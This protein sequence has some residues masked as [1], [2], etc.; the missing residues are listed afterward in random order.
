M[1]S[2]VLTQALVIGC[3]YATLALG[4]L[5]DVAAAGEKQNV[6]VLA[7]RDSQQPAYELFMG[8]FRAGL[9]ARAANRLELFTEFLDSTRFPQIE[10][11]MRMRQFL[12]EKY[13]ATRIDLVI[14]TSPVTLDFVLQ[15]RNALFPNVPVVFVL[16]SEYELPAKRLP[17]DV[18]GV[19]DRFDLAKTLE[20]AQRLQPRASQVVVVS[21]AGTFDKT[22]EDIARRELQVNDRGLE[23]SYLSGLPLGRLLEEV[24][25]LPRDT[26][27]LLLSFSRDG[28]G[29]LFRPPDVAPKVAAVSAAPMYSV[30]G[31]YSGRG[32]VGGYM[33]SLEAVG[34]RAA[35]VALRLLA[36]ERPEQVRAAL[37]P[38]GSYVADATE[39]QR[40]SLYE[41]RL[42]EGTV[43]RFREPS[44][45]IAYRWYI[46]AAA[47]AIVLQSLLIAA[48]I[49]QRRAR[50]RAEE[51]TQRRR[52]EL[53]QASR[54]ALAG[55]LTATIA[56]EINQ[57]LGAILANAG[58]AE[59]LLRRGVAS[60]DEMRAIIGDIKQA[61]IRAGEVIRRVR[62]LVT[63]R[64]VERE[65]VDV[66]AM[67][68]DVL[69][70][71]QGEAERRGVVVDAAYASELA[72]VLA[73]RVQLQQAI[74]NL[75][76]NSL[77]AMTGT[78]L[79][80]RRLSLRTRTGARGSIE[81][82]VGDTGPGIPLDQL[83]RLFDSFFTT[84]ADGM[85]LG[86]SISRSIVEQHEGELLAENRDRGALFR[87][88][89]PAYR[90][91]EPASDEASSD[92][93]APS[94]PART[95][96]KASS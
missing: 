87:I 29:E 52:A 54:L 78:A 32:V 37:G 49:F 91:G 96:S 47:A 93:A 95:I 39:M 16:V 18:I 53:A 72:P 43:V 15:H 11:A 88:V 35:A 60:G 85:G 89:L 24:A 14:S 2:L 73:D 50:R 67:V 55:E 69:A 17:D 23:F 6:L 44:I 36:G 75:C 86:L 27:V 81:I 22:F 28:T 46:A 34:E 59:A 63:T 5:A 48:L 65:V 26:I 79:E 76:V 83:P 62:A 20:M 30:F 31:V 68:R 41:S 1:P 10:H 8:G 3:V 13:A 90:E 66:N 77:D 33:N 71:L 25:H 4:L 80:K 51:E 61:D 38:E 45:W 40:W 92:E 19:L 9:N 42:P 84:K 57:P 21:G 82:A 64:Q 58:A 74:V 56:H 7:G 12:Q 70:F 94:P